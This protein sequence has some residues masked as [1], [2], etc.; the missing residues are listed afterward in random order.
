MAEHGEGSRGTSRIPGKETVT[1]DEIVRILDRYLAD[2]QLGKVPDKDEILAAYPA[3]A[4][5]LRP[6]LNGIDFI[7]KSQATAAIPQRVGR[8]EI[9]GTLGRGAFGVVCLARDTE[10]NRLVALKL[11][12]EGRFASHYDLEKFVVE[13]RTAAQL[14]HPGIVTVFDVFHEQERVV[15]VQQYIQG[16]DLRR[17]LEASGPL[18]AQR[19]A[20]LAMEIAE[21][22]SAAHQKGFVHRDLK[23]SNVLLDEQGHPHVADFGLALHK[24]TLP[25][26]RGDRSGTP[27]YMSPEQ[28]RGETDRLDGRS[29]IWSLGV[30]LYEMLT[31]ERPF[32]PEQAPDVF[33]QIL[34]QHPVP[35][36][37]LRSEIPDELERI[38]LTCLSKQETERYGC[39]DELAEDLRRFIAQATRAVTAASLAVLP[40]LD[41][42]ADKD[43]DYFCAGMTEELINRL[44]RV[45]NL[46]VVSQ[47]AVR[48]Y[49]DSRR[50]IREIGR[51]LHVDAILE[52]RVRRAGN[53]L[54]I[55]VHLVSVADSS[56]LWS[57]RFDRELR[58]V[59]A[60]QDE[61]AWNIVRSLELTLSVGEK[62]FL[63]SPPTTDVQAFDY[64]L[65]GRKFFYQYR[66]RGIEL[67]TQMFS[68][69][70][71][72]D[73][74]YALAYAGM[75][76]CY[77]FLYMYR[78]RSPESLEK[79]DTAS[80]RALAL[81]PDSAEA[82]TSRGG[83]LSLAGRHEEAELAFE[84]A[85]RLGPQL[86]DA[87]YLYARD[88]FA[89]GKLDKAVQ[90]FRRAAE[91]N[92]QDYQSPLL[93]AQCYEHLGRPADA[94][95][96][97]HLG[98]EI[99]QQRLTVSPDD[100][101]ALY[102]G[103]NALAALGDVDKSI[104]WA[105]L[106]TS[107][108]PEE[109]MVLY[110]VACIWSLAGK[111]EEALDY[112]EKAVHLGLRQKEWLDHDGNLDPL[113]EHPRFQAL[114]RELNGAVDH[115]G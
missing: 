21:A 76:D 92:P 68:L 4:D 59:F 101:R 110:N 93:I 6:C 81:A 74:Q 40:F 35:P 51:A 82:H 90:L 49:E 7:Q 52:G 36:Q 61:I 53:R 98:V 67:A 73:A 106:A 70:I 58:D 28:V 97:R 19:A 80:L 60:I 50:D 37:L 1:D 11:P 9:Q 69:A 41:A 78:E 15:I 114:V 23:P 83:V 55:T 79:A 32:R 109:P 115:P 31:G 89:Q 30:V 107:M 56:Q 91:V 10:L 113:R 87:Y 96:A 3:L 13:A 72:H 2:L 103:A 39:V 45:K 46:R 29:D 27:E 75:A 104:E 100:V 12:S 24:S 42:G 108:E 16:Q 22:L 95:A 105:T 63:Q 34:H 26:L 47:S 5:Q 99:V 65:R 44:A 88:A 84:T 77:C 54:R 43:Q 71:K 33:E 20:E 66:R 8:Y 17:H 111:R 18:D 85:V 57:E 112:L 25:S 94:K 14:E 48:K 64:Y 86:F 38:C 102:M 62:R